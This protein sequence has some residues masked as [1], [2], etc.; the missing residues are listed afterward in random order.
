M[1]KTAGITADDYKVDRFEKK[2]TK[3]GFKVLDKTPYKHNVTIIR[4][5]FKE[6]ELDKLTRTIQEIQMYFKRGN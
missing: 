4:V 1:I 3:A 5:Q 6:S 2:L